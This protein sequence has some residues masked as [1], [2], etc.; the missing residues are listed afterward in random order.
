MG[1]KVDV[2]KAAPREKIF[3]VLSSLVLTKVKKKLLEDLKMMLLL[4]RPHPCT[5]IFLELTNSNLDLLLFCY[6]R[7]KGMDYLLKGDGSAL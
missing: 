4:L 3:T 5:L 1:F 7:S 2:A 6:K